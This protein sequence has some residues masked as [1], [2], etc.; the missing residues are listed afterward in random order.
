[1]KTINNTKHT[2]MHIRKATVV[3]RAFCNNSLFKAYALTNFPIKKI[4]YVSPTYTTANE[5]FDKAYEF[6]ENLKTE[7]FTI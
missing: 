7:D 5:A 4:E 6:L 2:V 1:M 3:V